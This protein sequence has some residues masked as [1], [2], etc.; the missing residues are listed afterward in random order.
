M[1][2]LES[3]AVGVLLAFEIGDFLSDFVA[4]ELDADSAH[5][6]GRVQ[7]FDPNHVTGADPLACWLSRNLF[8]HL[9]GDFNDGADAE[10]R[11]SGKKDTA[12]RQVFRR[13]G[14]PRSE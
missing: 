6:G 1:A 12:F 5:A 9:D 3:S 13:G 8:G 4:V 14:L 11:V 2:G 7:R 10:F